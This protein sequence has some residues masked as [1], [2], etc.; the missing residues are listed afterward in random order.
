MKRFLL[1]ILAAAALASCTKPEPF[2]YRV[3]AF[4]YPQADMSLLA[5]D[6]MKYIF[7]DAAADFD[8]SGAKR[9]FAVF[10][11]TKSVSDS[12]Y[13]ATLNRYS[14]PLYKEPVL[15]DG[16]DKADSLGKADIKVS[17][18][19]YS[20][21]CLNMINVI[22]V[23]ASGEDKHTVNLVTRKKQLD[24]DTL[25]FELRHLPDPEPV[26][27]DAVTDYTFYSTFPLGNVMPEGESIVLK[28]D[29]TW[30]GQ[31]RSFSGKVKIDRK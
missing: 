28:V 15:V 1:I 19:W 29:W 24:K 14:V 7:P 22:K 9:V 30:E 13:Q 3:I 26:E 21:G 11:V 2:L 17:D 20:G 6:G 18:I 12:V 27:G 8:W 5:D 25:R 10:D 23:L 4:G 31:A 16:P